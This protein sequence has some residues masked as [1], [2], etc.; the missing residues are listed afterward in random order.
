MWK[1]PP[2]SLLYGRGSELSGISLGTSFVTHHWDSMVYP[3][4]VTPPFDHRRRLQRTFLLQSRL[5][6]GVTNQRGGVV[7]CTERRRRDD[8][9]DPRGHY[10]T[11]SQL[12]TT[13]VGV[14]RMG[15]EDT[16][17]RGRTVLDPARLET[18]G[19]WGLFS[20]SSE[21]P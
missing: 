10:R 1:D 3:S 11:L 20:R 16:R 9:V 21:C 13:G 19:Y 2:V 6:R 18:G 12:G 15:L 5:V 8:P 7:S 14:E 4:P 17:S